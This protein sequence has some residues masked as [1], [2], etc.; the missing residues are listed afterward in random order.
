MSNCF[1]VDNQRIG[2]S[3]VKSTSYF[4]KEKKINN[5][6]LSC[7][8]EN[9]AKF[10]GIILLFGLAG[11]GS[12]K[13]CDLTMPPSAHH[14]TEKPYIDR[15]CCY[16]PQT[17]YD[18][19]K[20]GWASWYGCSDHGKP[21]ATSIIFNKNFMTAAHRTL[22]L[23][24]VVE[25]TNL[26]NGKK[27]KLVVNDRG[28]FAKTHKRIIDLSERAAKILGFHKKGETKVRVKCLP[29]DSML[30]ALYYG[31]KPYIGEKRPLTEQE[32]KYI[33]E[34]ILKDKSL[35]CESLVKKRWVNGK[36]IRNG[37]NKR[38]CKSGCSRH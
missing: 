12:Y 25:V 20:V 18:Y 31:K 3:C 2:A 38:R 37:R 36:N 10:A 26:E 9:K 33:K 8:I 23:P 32:F 14:I 22:P 7:F 1:C 4:E 35:H 29:Y 17:K 28:P 15:G 30:A 16:A 11:C 27:L 19:C 5:V 34:T 24:C 21:T 6:A 13:K